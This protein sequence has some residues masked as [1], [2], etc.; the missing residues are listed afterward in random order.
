MTHG[1]YDVSFP[2][3]QVITFSNETGDFLLFSGKNFAKLEK[4]NLS[5]WNKRKLIKMV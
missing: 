3:F 4:V 1:K 5:A 2:P